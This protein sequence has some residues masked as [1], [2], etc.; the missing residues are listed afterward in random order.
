LGDKVLHLKRSDGSFEFR[1][2]SAAGLTG[3]FTIEMRVKRGDTVSNQY[4]LY[5]NND[6]GSQSN[7]MA[8]IILLGA[9]IRTHPTRGSGTSV[10][11]ADMAANTWYTAA[12]VVDTTTNTFDFYVD[13]VKVQAGASTRTVTGGKIDYLHIF[14]TDSTSDV[15]VDYLRVYGGGPQFRVFEVFTI[16]M[17]GDSTMCFYDDGSHNNSSY[18]VKQRGWGQYVQDYIDSRTARVSNQAY[19][20]AS[21]KTFTT[22]NSGGNYNNIFNNIKSGD[23]LLIQFGHNDGH[24]PANSESTDATLPTSTEGSFKWYLNEKYIKPARAKGAIPVLITPVCRRNPETGGRYPPGHEYE[25]NYRGHAD[26]VR[27]LAEETGAALIDLEKMSGDLL[28]SLSAS[29]GAAATAQLYAVKSSG[30]TDVTHFCEYGAKTICGLV[31]DDIIARNL[32]PGIL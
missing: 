29:E 16:F 23:Y 30:E 26:A 20:G 32:M 10:K 13:G 5:T 21:S 22:I 27:A 14:S 25:H 9:E 18:T 11:M 8:N 17:A 12:V 3:T 24:D 1:N 28:D 4:A 15:W 2:A 6:S 19:P 7:S 31:I